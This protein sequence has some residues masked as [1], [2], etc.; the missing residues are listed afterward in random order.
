MRVQ[1]EGDISIEVCIHIYIYI[2]MIH[3][4]L[5]RGCESDFYGILLLVIP[6]PILNLHTLSGFL[7]MLAAAAGF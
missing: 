4:S 6:T 1:N 5:Y 7:L 2:W 3:I